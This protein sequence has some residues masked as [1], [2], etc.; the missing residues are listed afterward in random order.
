[1]FNLAVSLEQL[2]LDALNIRNNLNLTLADVVLS[3]P[4]DIGQM[5][6]GDTLVR[7]T[8]PAR[9]VSVYEFIYS[10]WDFTSF[11]DVHDPVYTVTPGVFTHAQVL[12]LLN[13]RLATQMSPDAFEAGSWTVGAEPVV[14][15]LRP[16]AV[17]LMLKGI[18]ELT[19][20]PA[21]VLE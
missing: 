4:E 5:P 3:A 7:M 11:Y 15:Q 21:E 2:F 20:K 16:T 10:R 17:N 12:T 18:L 8:I 6:E 13:E 1:M 19:L 14:L 9:G